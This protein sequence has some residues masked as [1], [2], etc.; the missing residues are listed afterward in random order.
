MPGRSPTLVW[1]VMCDDLRLMTLCWSLATVYDAWTDLSSGYFHSCGVASA[2]SDPHLLRFMSGT[3][4][5]L[6][7]CSRSW[8]TAL[9]DVGGMT[10]TVRVILSAS[11]LAHCAD[12]VS[13]F[14]LHCALSWGHFCSSLR[15]SGLDLATTVAGPQSPPL[16]SGVICALL[17]TLVRF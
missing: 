8:T 13:M 9:Q 12:L 6:T 11:A 16:A 14:A 5:R 15:G 3:D 7:S 4:A 17:L 2:P 1:C 10:T